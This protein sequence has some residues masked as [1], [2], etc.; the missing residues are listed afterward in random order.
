[1]D[2][3][4]I[5]SRGTEKHIRGGERNKTATMIQGR[6]KWGNWRR[7]ENITSVCSFE[8]LYTFLLK[9]SELVHPTVLFK[10]EDEREMIKRTDSG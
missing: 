8:K 3:N 2:L 6:I 9:T 7:G 1:M 4:L 10:K 5:F